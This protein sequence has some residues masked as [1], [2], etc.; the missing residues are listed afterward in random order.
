MHLHFAKCNCTSFADPLFLASLCSYCCCRRCRRRR[1]RRCRKG[2]RWGR[3]EGHVLHLLFPYLFAF[4]RINCAPS[5]QF[6]DDVHYNIYRWW[7]WRCYFYHVLLPLC[8]TLCLVLGLCIF[9]MC[10]LVFQCN[11]FF[12]TNIMR[13]LVSKLRSS[14]GQEPI[15]F[16]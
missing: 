10:V 4:F 8:I 1:C 16:R 6:A 12:L 9:R 13:V 15:Q 7:R 2:E 5:L 11:F 14:H 3:K